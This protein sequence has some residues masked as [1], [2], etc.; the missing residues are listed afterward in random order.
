MKAYN[1]MKVRSLTR[2]LAVLGLTLTLV[3]SCGSDKKNSTSSSSSSSSSVLSTNDAT[4]ASQWANLKA[5]LRCTTNGSR[6]SDRYYYSSGNT[7][8]LTSGSVSGSVVGNYYGHAAQGHAFAVQKVSDGGTVYHNVVVSL[9]SDSE[10]NWAGT[11]TAWD[12]SDSLSNPRLSANRINSSSCAHDFMTGR[13]V[14]ASS[15]LQSEFY[16]DFAP[17]V[18]TSASCY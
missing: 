12:D 2:K 15:K 14:A 11:L 17:E 1:K 3:A 5:S 7:S 13:F 18:Q 4:F 8:T 10:T 16:M 6:A 9:C